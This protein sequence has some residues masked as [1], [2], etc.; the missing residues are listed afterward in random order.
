MGNLPAVVLVLAAIAVVIVVLD[1]MLPGPTS[2]AA[3]ALQHAVGGLRARSVAIP[4]FTIAYLD[5][6]RGEPLVLV[7]GIGA[8]KD[9]FAPIAPWLRG[10]GRIIA[11]DLPGFGASGKPPDADYSIEA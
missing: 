4:G 10:L 9:N 11:L 7:H 8:D 1:R 2:R 3:L 5:G 6:G